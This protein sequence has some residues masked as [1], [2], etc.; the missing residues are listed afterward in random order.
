MGLRRE[1]EGLWVRSTTLAP[2]WT[3]E[4]LI[5]SYK[6]FNGDVMVPEAG[7]EGQGLNELFLGKR[8]P[9]AAAMR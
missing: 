3:L 7:W 2:K 9:A 4:C 1:K 8:L 6:G 5:V